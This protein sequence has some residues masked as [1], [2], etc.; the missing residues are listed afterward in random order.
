MRKSSRK[1]EDI[2][3]ECIT[4]IIWRKTETQPGDIR[5]MIGVAA[6]ALSSGKVIEVSKSG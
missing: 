4:L 6:K 5:K 2:V 3:A 1:K